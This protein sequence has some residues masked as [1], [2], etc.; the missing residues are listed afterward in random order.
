[1]WSV[2]DSP[3]QIG[4]SK[5]VDALTS[6]TTMGIPLE[7]FVLILVQLSTTEGRLLE[8][9]DPNIFHSFSMVNGQWSMFMDLNVT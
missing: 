2:D 6:S 5:A 8:L 9:R 1:M 4:Y 7:C 3:Q